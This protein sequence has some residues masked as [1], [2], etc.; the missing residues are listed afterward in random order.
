MLTFLL[1]HEANLFIMENF[2]TF[3]CN[4]VMYYAHILSAAWCIAYPS[5]TNVSLK[6]NLSSTEQMVGSPLKRV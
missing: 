2:L 4:P 5:V 1:H 6:M 3:T